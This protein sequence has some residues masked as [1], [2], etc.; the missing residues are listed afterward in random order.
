MRRGRLILSMAGAMILS[1]AGAGAAEPVTG[2][3]ATLRVLA[4][5]DE[6]PEMFSFQE[7]G[8]PGFERELLEG[9]CRVHGMR[10]EVVPVP[11]FDR[12]IPMLL[13]GKG[14]VITGIVDTPARRQRV[15]FS[16]E[17]LPGRHLAVA[18]RPRPAPRAAELRGLRVGIIRGTSWEQAAVDAGVPGAN[19][20]AFPD[21]KALLAGLRAGQVN[22]VVM[23]LV[24][25]A[26]AQKHDRELVGGAFL[27]SLTVGAFAAR[28]RDEKL[29]AALNRYLQGTRQSQHALVFRY[30]SEEALSLIARARRE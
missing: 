14:D 27:G 4:A 29:L 18:R 19:R 22:A 1:A 15:A 23:D 16:T 30:L 2:L 17:V 3:P 21:T 13:D 5:A 8:P 28:P 12:L 10:M 26:L 11:D 9:F 25:F 7:K 20:V 6:M 24:D